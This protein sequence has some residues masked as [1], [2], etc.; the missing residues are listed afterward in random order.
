MWHKVPCSQDFSLSKTLGEPI[1]IRARLP[2]DSFSI[3]NGVIVANAR[4]WPELEEERNVLIVQ[5]TANKKQLKEIEDKILETLSASEGNVLEDESA[6]QILDSS[7]AL[8][9]EISKKQKI[10]DE[11][12]KK[13]EQSRAGYRPVAEHGSVLFSPP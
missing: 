11:T 7:K 10:A 1:K 9:N 4:R 12:E 8:S 6:I 3:N 2:T 5:S 13:I